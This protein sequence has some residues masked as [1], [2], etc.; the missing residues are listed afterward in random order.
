MLGPAVIKPNKGCFPQNP[1]GFGESLGKSGLKPAFSGK[2]KA[3]FPKTEVLG[4]L[5]GCF[6]YGW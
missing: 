1:V 2:F 5:Q 6:F 3:A 4:K